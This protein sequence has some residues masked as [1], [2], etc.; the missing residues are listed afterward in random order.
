MARCART[1]NLE[2]HHMRRDGGNDIS[3]AEVLCQK[4]HSHTST[5]GVAGK[6]PPAFD[7]AT[8]DRALKRAGYQC[9]CTR[10]G[11]CH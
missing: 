9:E 3:N 8:K 1:T 6:S 4:C 11:G 2:I 5:Y 10:S 7:Q